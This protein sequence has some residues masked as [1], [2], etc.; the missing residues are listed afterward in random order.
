M[1][2]MRVVVAG[3]T[4]AATSSADSTLVAA[5]PGASVP[6][7]SSARAGVPGGPPS[8]CAAATSP[9]RTTWV[10]AVSAGGVG[11]VAGVGAPRKPAGAACV[12][13]TVFPSLIHYPLALRSRRNLAARYRRARPH[14]LDAPP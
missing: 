6:S 7:S 3:A 10:D 8:A 12:S 4:S 14:A 5:A 9:G 11:P 13:R 1:P 2:W